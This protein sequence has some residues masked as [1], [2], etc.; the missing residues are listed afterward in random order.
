MFA[1]RSQHYVVMT[2]AVR[3]RVGASG[4]RLNSRPLCTI[5]M[6]YCTAL[7]CM[8]PGCLCGK[9]TWL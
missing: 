2:A 5:Q 7:Y 1:L 3:M 9:L 4:I 6:F 8:C